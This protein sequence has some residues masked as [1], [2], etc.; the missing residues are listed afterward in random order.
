MQSFPIELTL[1][2]ADVYAYTLTGNE[3]GDTFK[4]SK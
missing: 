3:P 4:N 2:L 1:K